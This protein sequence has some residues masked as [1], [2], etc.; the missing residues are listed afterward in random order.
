MTSSQHAVM[1]KIWPGR[2][3]QIRK[4]GYA[5]KLQEQR[6]R[7]SKDATQTYRSILR[8][9]QG[10]EYAMSVCH[11]HYVCMKHTER[12]QKAQVSMKGDGCFPDA[13]PTA[14]SW[15]SQNR[16]KKSAE[17]L[18]PKR[19]TWNGLKG[20]LRSEPLA[21]S[22]STETHCRVVLCS[23]ISFSAASLHIN[24]KRRRKEEK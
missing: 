24:V 23:S 16:W 6:G 5:I 13:S 7:I 19:Q 20:F 2:I 1:K 14:A 12:W 4:K 8:Y 17:A 11:Q 15:Q 10:V 21:F 3:G 22:A 9:F 18:P